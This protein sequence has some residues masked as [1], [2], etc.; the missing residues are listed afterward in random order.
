[1]SSIQEKIDK[2]Q[3]NCYD[4]AKNEANKL[5]VEIE[6]KIDKNIKDEIRLYKKDSELKYERRANQIE[7]NY[8][9]DVYDAEN[10]AKHIII[11]KK[12]NIKKD[13]QNEVI[14][15]I[16]E[17]IKSYDYQYYLINNIDE[18][19]QNLKIEEGDVVTIGITPEDYNVYQG[20]IK[21]KFGYS[22]NTILSKNL[23]GS[24][25]INESKKISINNTLKTLIEEN[26]IDKG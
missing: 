12:D 22:I 13:L 25:C 10:K 2:F 17:F 14:K 26:F 3:L 15:R 9:C 19:I 23:G 16:K 1:M 5:T 21:N 20:E 18:A 24:I 7:Q 4:I 8:N 11:E 6:E